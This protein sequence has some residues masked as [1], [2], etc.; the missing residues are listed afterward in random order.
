MTRRLSLLLLVGCVCALSIARGATRNVPFPSA[1]ATTSSA[2]DS[3]LLDQYPDAYAAYSLRKLRSDY[4]GPAIRVRRAS[5]SAEQDFGFTGEGNL[6]ISAVE[7]WLGED[8]GFVVEWYSQIDGHPSATP[9]GS[10]PPRIAQGG[11]VHTDE[12]GNPR[13]YFHGVEESGMETGSLPTS[14]PKQDFLALAVIEESDKG[15]FFA[16][17]NSATDRVYFDRSSTW[18][19]RGN[20]SGAWGDSMD[21]LDI[22]TQRNVTSL[23]AGGDTQGA[24]VYMDAEQIRNKDVWLQDTTVP[25]VEIGFHRGSRYEGYVNEVVVYP[26]QEKLDYLARYDNINAYWDAGPTDYDPAALLPQQFDWQIGLYSWL[27]TLTVEDVELPADGTMEWDETYSNIDELADLHQRLASAS[28]TRVVRGE[29]EWY[30]L[31][32]GN[33]KGIQAT[34]EVRIWHSTGSGNKRSWANEPAYLYQLDV[35]LSGGGQGNPFYQEDALAYRA[36]VLATVDMM[37]YENGITNRLDMYG[38]AMKGWAE[39]Y[40]WA[41]NILSSETKTAFEAG[42]DGFLDRMIQQGANDVNT[43][44]DM[45][46]VHAAAD[47]WMATDDTDLQDKCVRAVKRVLFG[48]TDGALETNHIVKNRPDGEEGGVFFPAGYVGENDTPEIYYNGESVY[49]L[50]GAYAAVQDRADGSL[51]ADWQFLGDVLERAAEWQ[52]YMSFSDVDGFRTGPSGFS[53]RTSAGEPRTQAT[54]TYRNMTL[55][56]ETTAGTFQLWDPSRRGRGDYIEN[57]AT[58]LIGEINFIIDNDLKSMNDTYTGEPPA[59]TGWSPWVKETTYLPQEGWFSDLQAV[60]DDPEGYAPMERPG[61]T[62][63]KA[64]GGPPTGKEFWA[65]KDTDPNGDEWGFVVEA[66]ESQGGYNGWTG[67]RLEMFWSEQGGIVVVN[68]HGKSGPDCGDSSGHSTC[69]EALNTYPVHHVWGENADGRFTSAFGRGGLNSESGPYRSVTWDEEGSPPTV[70][71]SNDIHSDGSFYQSG[72]ISGSVTVENKFEAMGN[73]LQV[74]HTISSSEADQVTELWASLPIHLKDS[75]NSTQGDLAPTSIEYWDGSSWR[76]MPDPDSGTPSTVTTD[77]LRLGRDFQNGAGIQYS[78]A[79]F[80]EVQ[81]MR[82]SEEVY[83]DPYQTG[84]DARTVHIDLH[85]DPGTTKTLPA[86]KSVSYTIQTTEP[87]LGALFT[88]Q[89]VSLR[90]GSN[91]ISAAL[92]PEHAHMDSVFAG[93]AADVVEV[94]NEAGERY[95]PADGVNEIGHWDRDEAYV[96]YAESGGTLSLQGTPVDTSSIALDEGW[97]WVPYSRPSALAV[98]EALTSI[99]DVLVMVKDE[100][101]RAYVPGEGIEELSTLTP[102]EGYRVYVSSSTTLTYPA[103]SN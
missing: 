100:T 92:A 21:D 23:A 1:E 57:T 37:M 79:S 60:K 33:G 96:V 19:S 101:G 95:R 61:H 15:I 26:Y 91:L 10:Q 71:V 70:T 11:T 9:Q 5:D 8:D 73:G 86:S 89:D 102:G 69:W 68:R 77:A 3:L 64:L 55:A 52:A 59:W 83:S 75:W 94:K 76:T 103:G 18:G 34:D 63:N 84:T 82:L 99:Q 97:N 45:F 81:T 38:K 78:Y 16:L 93:V 67:G 32:A 22:T 46:S 4:Q 65:Y 36:M 62:F 56:K 12:N 31:D 80:A 49:H 44:M 24:Q 85:G 7:E 27:E 53:G 88:E 87:A 47:M 29:P 42:F 66:Q 51:P 6:N 74:T 54:E 30:V 58:D 48:Y 40:R 41:G 2:A 50:A 39:A 14:I 25:T 20:G 72:V 17:N 90:K 43:N 35:P 28:A 13:L 98:E